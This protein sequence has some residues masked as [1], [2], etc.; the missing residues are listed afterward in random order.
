MTAS[1][2]GLHVNLLDALGMRLVTGTLHP[3][4][5]L[6]LEAIADEHGVSRPV[7]REAVRVLQSMGMLASRR[8]VGVTVLP[9]SEWNVFDPRLIRWRLD[10]DGRDA[11]LLSL[12]E[13]RR[14]FEPVAAGLAAERATPEQCKTLAG[15]ASDMLVLGRAG[16]LEAYLRADLVFHHTLLEASGNEMLQAMAEVVTQVLAGRTHHGLMPSTPNPQAIAMHEAV[17]QAVR[18]QDAA[19]AEVAM[20]AII[21]ESAAAM[22]AE[23]S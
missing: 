5:V 19:G 20:R 9:K 23:F 16:D 18:S 8:R 7:A 22:R 4:Q 17:A 21:D 15:A 2:P 14:G 11:Q 12:S 3:G 1:G 10:S 13:L 6:T